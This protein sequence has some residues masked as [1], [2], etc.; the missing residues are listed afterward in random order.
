MSIFGNITKGLTNLLDFSSNEEDLNSLSKE[1]LLKKVSSINAENVSMQKSIN[2]ISKENYLLSNSIIN[3]NN[4]KNSE[5]SKFLNVMQMNLL[6]LNNINNINY[7]NN[8]FK[9]FLYNEKLFYGWIKL[10][11][12]KIN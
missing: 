2:E 3:D 4:K 9:K 7:T 6:H 11:E 5:F 12:K 10:I 1:D 8:D